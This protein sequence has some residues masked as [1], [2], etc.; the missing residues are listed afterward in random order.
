MGGWQ[1]VR[2]IWLAVDDSEEESGAGAKECAKSPET[3][4]G[5]KMDLPLESLKRCAVLP[6]P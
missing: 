4:R 2:R 6:K 5:K 3:G 1:G